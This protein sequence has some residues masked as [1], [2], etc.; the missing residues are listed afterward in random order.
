MPIGTTASYWWFA[1]S[2]T[3]WDVGA[4]PDIAEEMADYARGL[5]DA[6]AAWSCGISWQ[7]VEEFQEYWLVDT[8]EDA[9]RFH[10]YRLAVDSLRVELANA[11]LKGS[12]NDRASDVVS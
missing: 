8:S 12:Q 7:F 2:E 10:Y 1:L 11:I 5:S 9:A 4:P 6:W 3:L